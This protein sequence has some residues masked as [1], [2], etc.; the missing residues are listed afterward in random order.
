MN[1]LLIAGWLLFA[2]SVCI[3]FIVVRVDKYK[4]NNE[5]SDANSLQKSTFYRYL[6]VLSGIC[7]LIICAI[8]SALIIAS[9]LSDP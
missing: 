1:D 8:G 7:A 5:S 9:V 2:L 3:V 4:N 6:L